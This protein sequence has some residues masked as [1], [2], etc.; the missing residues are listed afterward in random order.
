M[1][2]I[3]RIY[4]MNRKV[5]GQSGFVSPDREAVYLS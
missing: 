2:A 4:I 1:K 5:D 3:R